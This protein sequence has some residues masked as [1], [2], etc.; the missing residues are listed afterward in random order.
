MDN[1]LAKPFGKKPITLRAHTDH[2]VSEVEQLLDARPYW[3]EK[4]RKYSAIS[5]REQVCRAAELHDVGKA[6]QTWQDACQKDRIRYLETGKEINSNIR[7]A[8]LRHEF[9]SIRWADDNNVNLTLAEKA[10]IAAHHG[11]LSF[12]HQHRWKKDGG[13]SFE[14]IWESFEGV[15]YTEDGSLASTL[16]KRY[17]IAGVRSILRL[18]DARASAREV[19]EKPPPIS[20]N[21]DFEFT[22]EHKRPVQQAALEHAEKQELIMRAPTGSGKTVAALLWAQQQIL[23]GNAD[24]LVIAMPT[25]FTSTSLDIDISEDVSDTGLYHSSAWF[26]RYKKE[27]KRDDNNR[28]QAKEVL[29][30]A[31][32]LMM[33]ANVTTI[34][35]LLMA[36]TGTREDHH[37]IFFNLMNSCIVIDEADFYDEFI[38]A[39]IT[40]LLE[41]LRVFDIRILIMSATVPE[42]TKALYNIET[43]VDPYSL[44]NPVSPEA[45]REARRT[46]CT[47]RRHGPVEPEEVLDSIFD[48]LDIESVD[49][50][51]IYANTV[52]R[53]LKYYDWFIKRNK[54]P[55]LY[56]S[57]FTEPDKNHIES[58]LIDALGRKAWEKRE[59]KGVAILTQIGEMSLNISAKQMISDLCPMD[60]LAQ[61]AGR[62]SRFEGMEPGIL[63][64]LKPMKNGEIYPAPYGE[65]DRKEKSWTPVPAFTNTDKM[66]NEKAYNANDF[67]EVVNSL[68]PEQA[69][70]SDRS[71]M[72]RKELE[73][74]LH[75]NWLVLP[76]SESQEDDFE[77]SEWLSRD[78]P[79]QRTVFTQK[80]PLNFNTFG[81]YREFQLEYG[82]SCPVW[83][84]QRGKNFKQKRVF[85]VQLYVDDE[86]VEQVPYSPFY[87]PTEGLILDQDR[88]K[89]KR[90]QFV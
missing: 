4:Y 56:H 54:E 87:S 63:H 42:S 77:T 33:P 72:N 60:R 37:A 38:Q 86:K 14:Y 55:I 50:L 59:A 48:N 74:M 90:D 82:I 85:E 88:E 49:P 65:Y 75:D 64:I 36:L 20:N 35:H 43:L 39:N 53:A 17:V 68:Y 24:R 30:L 62:L 79:V 12:G 71:K 1:Y 26:A 13:G 76:A 58:D 18:A 47:I 32:L 5:L 61:R 34:D 69:G 21:F 3:E 52:V 78:I 16:R 40:K 44:S 45:K 73:Q 6:H 15:V 28:R 66:L 31:R 29:K 41:A 22:F 2:V 67:V 8:G 19:G 9:D 89:S 27:A 11:K 23:H 51:I 46:R 84:I 10:A 25:R 81:E 83:Q 57:R 7:F 70:F 80:P